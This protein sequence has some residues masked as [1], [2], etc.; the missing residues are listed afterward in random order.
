MERGGELV[1]PRV[2]A[3]EDVSVEFAANDAGDVERNRPPTPVPVDD[4]LSGGVR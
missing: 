2:E 3:V 1:R 4:P